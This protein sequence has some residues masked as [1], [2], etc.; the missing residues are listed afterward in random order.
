MWIHR[1]P[2]FEGKTSKLSTE[3]KTNQQS[4]TKHSK[5]EQKSG[6]KGNHEPA[7]VELK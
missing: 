6:E 7:T 5:T 4:K 3:E 2:S 1:W